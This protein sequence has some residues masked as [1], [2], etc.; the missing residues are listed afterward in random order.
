VNLGWALAEMKRV[1]V[2]A[3]LTGAERV[4]LAY[5]RAAELAEADVTVCRALGE[6]GLGLLQRTTARSGPL[7]VLTHCN[8][9]WLATVDWGTALAPIYAARR[10]GLEVEVWVEET[11]PRNQ[12]L[13]TAWELEQEG[14]PYRLIADNAG[15][16]FMQQG[17]A[18]LCIVGTDR[19]TRNGDVANKIGTYQKALAARDTEV[20]FWVALPRS[21]FDPSLADGRAI[22]IEERDSE[23]L[24]TLV[25]LDQRGELGAVRLAPPGT[26]ARNP[27]FDLTPARLVTGFITEHGLCAPHE[28]EALFGA[29]T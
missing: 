17:E 16:Y 6:H 18:D 27:A 23:E 20:P 1:L 14:V 11:R 9:G 19:T 2:D 25:G 28:L 13:L 29:H 26:P 24:L 3:E 22:P 4:E 10:L 8:A 15:G 21:S 12:G 5:R 7:R